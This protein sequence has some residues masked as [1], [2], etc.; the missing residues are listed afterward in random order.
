MPYFGIVKDC[1]L[2]LTYR[3]LNR[4]REYRNNVFINLSNWTI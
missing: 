4:D 2:P 1:F 3:N